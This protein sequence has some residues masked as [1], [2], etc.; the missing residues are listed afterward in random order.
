MPFEDVYKKTEKFEGGY[1]NDPQDKGGETFRGISRKA[2][3]DWEG[4][5]LIDAA[6]ELVGDTPRA[7]DRHFENDQEMAAMVS[8]F[9]RVN[10]W[11][12]FDKKGVSK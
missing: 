10:Y 5:P 6:K 12:P 4:W 2:H 8:R 11:Q 7:I 9:Y 3:P 1:V